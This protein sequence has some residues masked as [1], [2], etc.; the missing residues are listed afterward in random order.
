MEL[1]TGV[2]RMVKGPGVSAVAE[3]PVARK[4][5]VIKGPTRFGQRVLSDSFRGCRG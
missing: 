1:K 5:E 3:R 4:N 2:N